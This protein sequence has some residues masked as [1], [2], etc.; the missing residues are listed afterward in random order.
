MHL[1]NLKKSL[2]S[3]YICLVALLA[4]VTFVEH[5][6]GTEFVEKYV[7]HTVWFCCLWGVL[8]ALAV[9]V[10]VKRQLWR[11][12]PALLLHGSF[13]FILVG[14]MITFSCSKKGY[15]HLTVGTEVG[16]FIDQDSKRVIEL[17]FTLCLD[18][19][20]VEYYPGTEAPADYVSYIRDA[21]PVSMNRILSRQGYRFYQS[22]FDDDKEG[23]W[24]S[25]NYDPWGIGVT[26][27]GYILLGISMLWMLVGRSGEFRRLLRHPLLRKG[28]MFVWLLMAVVTVV[29]AEN[30]SL[31]ALALRQADSL[32]FKQ[33][34]YHDRVVPFNTLA[35]DFVLKLTGKP[36]Y[37]DIAAEYIRYTLDCQRTE[38]LKDKDGT[39]GFFYR[40]KSRKSIVHYIHQSREQVYMQAMVMLCETQKEHPD[41][42]KW[43][44]SIQLYGEYLK[45]MMKYTHPY[46]MIP[47]GVYHAEEYKDT[48]NFYALHLFPP[49]NAK[50]LY[51]EQIKRGVQLDKEHYMKR[52]PVWFN[53]FNGN[54]AIH[55]SNGKSA[56]IC[57]NFLKDKELLNIGLEQLYWTVGKNPFGQS[58]IYGEGHNYPQLN[59]FSSGEM[60][61]EMPVGIRTLGNDDVPY[62]PQTNNACYKEVW[63][64]S[65]G[66]WLSLIAEY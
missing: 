1:F 50:E 11:H 26:Y 18:S 49:A 60:T 30:R 29:Q 42:P 48:T 10:L 4:V 27:A 13:L 39:R 56:A 55:L 38:P 33:V 51:T 5:V 32:A 8:A 35:R 58:L 15:M 20:R 9:V 40:D 16:T 52:F 2:V 61:G 12:L 66:K 25:V 62:W 36:S 22:S 37:A 44:N 6:R 57:G 3:L 41:Y 19:F 14:A 7:Y 45:G 65:A 63:I 53:I 24:L 64:T 17:P 28:G 21:E 23:S 46:G 47:S 31:P 43:V 34:I 54:T 59:T